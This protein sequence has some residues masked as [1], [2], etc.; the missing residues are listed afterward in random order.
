VITDTLGNFP[1]GWEKISTG[2]FAPV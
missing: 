2:G 1:I